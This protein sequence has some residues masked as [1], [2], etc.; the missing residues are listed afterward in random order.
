MHQLP[1]QPQSRHAPALPDALSGCLATFLRTRLQRQSTLVLL[2]P[3][4]IRSIPCSH[5]RDVDDAG[6][7]QCSNI[8]LVKSAERPESRLAHEQ[9][10][11]SNRRLRME[12]CRV[13]AVRSYRRGTHVWR[14]QTHSKQLVTFSEFSVWQ[15]RAA[16]GAGRC[17]RQPQQVFSGSMCRTHRYSSELTA[18]PTATTAAGTMPHIHDS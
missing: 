17:A 4:R 1:Q 8:Q 18:P 7:D 11:R 13:T 16:S 3:S 6:I 10:D 14:R 15:V 5:K 9:H 12:S 2:V